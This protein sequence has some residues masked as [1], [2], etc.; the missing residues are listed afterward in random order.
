MQPIPAPVRARPL[1]QP[2]AMRVVPRAVSPMGNAAF[3]RISASFPGD[4][5]P[6]CYSL[7]D[8]KYRRE[9]AEVVLFRF[10]LVE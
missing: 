7:A 10:R 5:P 2:R 8:A 1:I 9:S 6:S 3:S 4:C